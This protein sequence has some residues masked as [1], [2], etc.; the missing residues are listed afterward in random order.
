MIT[1]RIAKVV[2]NSNAV[3]FCHPVISDT[4]IFEVCKLGIDSWADTCCSGKNTFFEEF[5]E[6]KTVTATGLTSYLG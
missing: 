6:S 2:T 1:S 4:E 5:I 3:T